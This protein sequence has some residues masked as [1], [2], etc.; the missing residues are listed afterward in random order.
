MPEDVCDACGAH[1]KG[2]GHLC[3]ECALAYE[4]YLA[5]QNRDWWS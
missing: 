5:E 1:T 3:R 4:E 2:W